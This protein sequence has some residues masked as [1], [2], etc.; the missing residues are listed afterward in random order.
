[1]LAVGAVVM[2]GAM[3]GC[4]AKYSPVSNTVEVSDTDFSSIDTMLVGESCQSYLFSVLAIGG[5]ASMI[6]AIANS[7]ISYVRAV[8]YR[9]KNFIVLGQRCVVVYGE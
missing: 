7:G 2:A 9:A 4:M 5:S 1:M 3:S 6:D 8:D